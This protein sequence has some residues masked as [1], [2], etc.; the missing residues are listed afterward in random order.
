MATNERQILMKKHDRVQPAYLKIN[1][2]LTIAILITK[3][4]LKSS[5]SF[6]NNIAQKIDQKIQNPI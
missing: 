1:S 2:S 3:K 6:W 4:L 5:I